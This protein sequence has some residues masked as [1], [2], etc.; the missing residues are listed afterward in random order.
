MKVLYDIQD[1]LEDELKKISKKEEITSTDLDNIYKMVDIVKDVTTVD[2]MHKAE[3]DGYSRDYARDY[4][5]GYSDDYANAYGSYNSYARRGRDGDGDGR[6]SEDGSYRRGHDAMGRYTS[7][8]SSYDGYSR[9]SK[10]E[11]I[12]HLKEMMRNARSE[13]E[14]ESYRKTIEQLQR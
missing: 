5:R 9:H 12:E 7:R 1:M 8:D 6:Y 13:E 11:M 4:S 3:Q 2:A 14:R 10:E